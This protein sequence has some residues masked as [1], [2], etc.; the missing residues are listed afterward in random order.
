MKASHFDLPGVDGKHHSPAS[1]RGANGLVVMFICNHCP[2][3]KRSLERILRDSRPGDGDD[4]RRAGHS[5]QLDRLLDQ[6][7]EV[8]W[9]I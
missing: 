2:Y 5:D 4:R 9:V 8:A 7:E 3:V 6:V 1:A